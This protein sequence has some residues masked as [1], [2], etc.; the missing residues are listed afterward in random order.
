MKGVVAVGPSAAFWPAGVS[1]PRRNPASHR[2]WAPA[3]G[4]SAGGRDHPEGDD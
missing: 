2:A 3:N 1:G 4:E